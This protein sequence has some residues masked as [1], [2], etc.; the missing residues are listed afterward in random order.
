VQLFQNLLANGV[1]F[2]REDAPSVH[3]EARR[4]GSAWVL[5]FQDNGIGIPAEE[6]DRLFQPF[7]R[8][9]SG[10]RFRGTGLGLATCRRIVEYHGGKIWVESEPGRGTTV[11]FTLPD[12]EPGA[13]SSGAFKSS[14][15]TRGLPR[16][17]GA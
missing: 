5:A 3:V 2:R 17:P 15:P 4:Q 1:K 16:A 10:Q 7:Q 12:F 11:F 14:P 6:K 13:R 9:S 8:L